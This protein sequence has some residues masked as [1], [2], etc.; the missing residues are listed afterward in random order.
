MVHSW[1]GLVC[2]LMSRN[3]REV[4][5]VVLC[6]MKYNTIDD[7]ICILLQ[8]NHELRSQ[9]F[10]TRGG[11]CLKCKDS[12]V[13]DNGPV[14]LLMPLHTHGS[15]ECRESPSSW[16]TGDWLVKLNLNVKSNFETI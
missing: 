10:I 4:R 13:F 15:V 1:F 7:D 8:Y 9:K 3:G 5:S 6:W 11:Y 2:S 12:S 16:S 14:L